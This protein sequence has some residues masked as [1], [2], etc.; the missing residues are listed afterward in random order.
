MLTGPSSGVF[1]PTYLSVAI[2]KPDAAIKL[3]IPPSFGLI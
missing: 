1:V 2:L 3:Q